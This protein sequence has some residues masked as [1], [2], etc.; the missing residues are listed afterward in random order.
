MQRDSLARA[1][2]DAGSIQTGSVPSEAFLF[3][4]QLS[5]SSSSGSFKV[6]WG[7]CHVTIDIATKM[8]A[9]WKQGEGSIASYTCPEWHPDTWY[10]LCI[11]TWPDRVAVAWGSSETPSPVLT[12]QVTP[13]VTWGRDTV[14]SGYGGSELRV[15]YL[16]VEPILHVAHGMDVAKGI[17]AQYVS[18][19]GAGATNVASAHVVG[20]DALSGP[21][22]WMGLRAVAGTAPLSGYRGVSLH[23]AEGHILLAANQVGIGGWT[24]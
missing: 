16:T 22:P 24:R 14:V 6:D 19:T 7:F 5:S 21:V 13:G 9:V 17:R 18:V 23:A 15:R 12:A 20:A 1:A 10:T 8:L 4:G 2:T 11:R 3:R